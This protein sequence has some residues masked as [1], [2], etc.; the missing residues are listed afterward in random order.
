MTSRHLCC[1]G[2]LLL[3]ILAPF[4]A[5]GAGRI[6]EATYPPSEKPGELVYGVTFRA[7]IPDGV[8]R[9]RGLIVHQHGCGKGACQG[10][11][12][13]ADD[14]HWQA[15]AAKW[16][17]ALLGPSYHQEDGQNCRLWCD[18]RNG[19]RTRFLQA[20]D[21]LAAS[22]KPSGAG[23]RPVVPLGPFRR[24]FLGQPDAGIRPRAD[25]RRLAPL[26]HRLRHLGEGR[27]HPARDLRSGLSDPRHV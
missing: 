22:R 17:C 27:C 25:R 18:P 7:W 16:G 4:S 21:D 2:L 5:F 24:R 10:G 19:S 20:L 23:D 3:T 26:G 14:L 6:V 1:P 8:G 15:L 9:L 13:A 11:E 12:T